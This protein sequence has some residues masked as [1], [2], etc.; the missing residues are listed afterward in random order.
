[1]SDTI[2]L[3]LS[4]AQDLLTHGFQAAGVPASTATSVAQALTLAQAEGQAGHGFSRFESY[5]A[6]AKSGKVDAVAQPVMTLQGAAVVHVDAQ[7]GFAYPAIDLALDR[8]LPLAQDT[9]ISVMTITRSH[10]CGALSMHVE[11]IA[12]AGLIGLMVANTPK[13]MAPWGGDAAIF[14]TNPIAFACPCADGPPLVIDLSLSIVARGKVMA[15]QKAGTPIPEGWALGPDG[16]PTTDPATALKGTM[17]PIGGAKG[18]ALALMVEILAAGLTGATF[19]K[20]ATS[21]FDAKGAPPAVGQ[22]LIA[23]RP[24]SGFMGR[25]GGLLDDIA[26][27]PGT[28]IPGARR[29]AA[30]AEAKQNGMHVPAQ[31]VH[32]VQDTI[33]A[34]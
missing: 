14:G 12:Q 1:M 22:T 3:T 32:Q 33:N 15:A 8:G 9:G 7:L 21:F 10:H 25:V 19:S 4:A 30:L 23:I 18:S 34:A 20:D 29:Q 31:L 26:A 13:A 24:D 11:R 2:H 5:A 16:Q 28:R 17:V 6:Q 27:M